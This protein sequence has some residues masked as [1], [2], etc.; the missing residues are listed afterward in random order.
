MRFGLAG[1]GYWA[2]VT[3]AAAI[4]STPGA[5]LNAVWGRN[6]QAAK[7]LAAEHGAT[8]FTGEDA[9][10]AFL[11]SVDAVS[12]SVPPH[13]QAP[14][15]TRAARAGKHLLLEK[16]IAL[17]E[18]D[19]D[20]LVAAVDQAGVASV[21][22]FT[23][24][25]FGEI[26]A[27]LADE[28]ARG[29]WTGQGWSG[30][31]GEWLGSVI[32][33]ESPFNT[34]WRAEKGGLWDVGP[35]VLSLLWAS[36][37]PVT[38]VAATAG[39]ADLVHLVL[40]HE[41]GASSTVTVTLSAP[42]AA[43]AT[44]L[45]VWGEAGRSI[46]PATAWDPVEC[47]RTALAELIANAGAG[48]TGH[49][50]DVRFGRAINRVLAAAQAQLDSRLQQV[51]LPAPLVGVG[52]LAGDRGLPGI[53]GGDRLRHRRGQREGPVKAGDAEEPGDP[54]RAGRQDQGSFDGAQPLVPADDRAQARRVQEL[55]PAQVRDD[56]RDVAGDE[57]QDSLPQVRRGVH[58]D[59]TPD[60]NERTVATD[61]D[62]FEAEGVLHAVLRYL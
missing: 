30:G 29:G 46:M 58:V 48:E 6:Q 36:L 34:P 53:L 18:E 33:P 12:F 2:R 17:S 11:D 14:I 43:A 49:P 22:F 3:H 56:V 21:V 59:L 41:S 13:I 62:G 10:D 32:S 8:A 5:T 55:H 50:C 16:P 40:T 54:F 37:G 45:Y 47:L 27:W 24:R 31:H 23:L 9:I 28:N 25:F 26:R 51:V 39:Q 57:P 38:N 35:H 60:T 19:A 52:A 7:D 4:S 15:A 61:G 42:S 1:T 44:N 20:A